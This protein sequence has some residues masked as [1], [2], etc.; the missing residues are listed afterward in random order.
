YTQGKTQRSMTQ[1]MH[2]A[3]TLRHI[4]PEDLQDTARLLLL[5]EQAYQEGLIGKSESERLTFVSLAEHARVVGAQNPCG[6]FAELLRRER[7]HFITEHDE[8]AA[9]A[10]LK[11]HFYGIR[12]QRQ[13]LPQPPALP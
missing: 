6:L 3:P 8:D 11:A 7:W 12:S 10:R 9:Y 13:C 1:P 4:V 2:F 5:F